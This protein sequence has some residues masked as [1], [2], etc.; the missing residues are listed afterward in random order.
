M[1]NKPIAL[2]L[3]LIL[4][5]GAIWY[6]DSTKIN[7]PQGGQTIAL[8]TPAPTVSS[9]N[10][11]ASTSSVINKLEDRTAI[12]RTKASKFSSAVELVPGGQFINSDPFT[13][14]QL[15]GKKVVLVDFW[16]YS[17]INC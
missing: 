1:T 9:S 14:K 17:C 15:V 16:T 7:I 13:L 2:L 5:V 4:I 3:V 10:E 8:T 11:S 12:L 6:L